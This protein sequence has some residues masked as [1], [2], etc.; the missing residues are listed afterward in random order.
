MSQPFDRG[1]QVPAPAELDDS[2]DEFWS[3]NA[4]DISMSHNLSG[5]ER[6]RTYLNAAGKNFVDIS[7]VSGADSDGDGRCVVPL[8]FNNDGR[9]DLLVRQV[10]GG[11]LK[12]FENNFPK[13]N[14]LRVS[15]RGVESNRLGIGARLV[16][17]IG[18]RQVVRELWPANTFYSQAPASV[19]LG[20]G[21]D[22]KVDE[23]SI[24]WPS[25]KVQKLKGIAAN[26]HILIKE[27]ADKVHTVK[28]GEKMPF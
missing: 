12:L 22:E 11:P 28:P 13:Q 9:Q 15:L 7:F 25:G 24:R 3:G 21:P 14:W 19:H 23:L 17:K 1:C 4:F 8:D 10:G 26:R 5:Y 16:A 20:L 18:K 6:N 27:G 2:L